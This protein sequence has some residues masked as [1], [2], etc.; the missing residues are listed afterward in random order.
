M[1]GKRYQVIVSPPA[2]RM[3]VFHADFL[4]GASIEAAEKL[5]AEFQKTA[6]SLSELPERGR[7]L[8]EEYIPFH[9]YR[10]FVFHKWY[11]LI[12]QVIDNTVY[13]DYVIDGRQD[14]QRL[15]DRL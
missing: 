11:L 14:H 1:P 4:A 9:K 7:R 13:V 10:C 3:M 8:A 2:A 6:D 12:C 5:L 15:F